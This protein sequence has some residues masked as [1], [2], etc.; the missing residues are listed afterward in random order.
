MLGPALLRLLL[1]TMARPPG[2][3]RKMHYCLRRG[4]ETWQLGDEELGRAFLDGRPR[5]PR[6]KPAGQQGWSLRLWVKNTHCL[7]MHQGVGQRI[8]PRGPVNLKYGVATPP[9]PLGLLR[10][11]RP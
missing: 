1:P 4:P 5:D 2:P 6:T 8:P 7:M 3:Q 10:L 11:L 9:L